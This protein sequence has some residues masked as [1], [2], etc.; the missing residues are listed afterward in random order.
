MG[1]EG[2]EIVLSCEEEFCVE[3][4]DS[5]VATFL[6]P[7]DM[8]ACIWRK[9]EDRETGDDSFCRT[10]AAFYRLRRAIVSAWEV[11]RVSVRPGTPVA[12]LLENHKPADAWRKLAL[13][14]GREVRPRLVPPKWPRRTLLLGGFGVPVCGIAWCPG[15]LSVDMAWVVLPV[16]L[17]MFTGMLLIAAESIERRICLNLPDN[18][19]VS[20]LL[21][22]VPDQCGSVWT[23]ETVANGVRRIVIETLGTDQ[24]LYHEDAEFVRDLGLG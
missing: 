19:H 21:R 14:L 18:L 4:T 1:L 22:S 3:L 8:I 13:E 9:I 24:N 23:R 15:V 16:G 17:F 12:K 7:R 6:T 5:E 20:D 11:P 2:V 10:Q